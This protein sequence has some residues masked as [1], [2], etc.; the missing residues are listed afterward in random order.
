MSYDI[1][2]I[3]LMLL[4]DVELNPGPATHNQKKNCRVLYSNIRGLQT[5]F[6]YLK[7]YARSYDL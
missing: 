5:N 3:L 2:V 1:D 6:L 7:S 4:G